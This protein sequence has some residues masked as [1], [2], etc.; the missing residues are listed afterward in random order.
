MRNAW[1]LVLATML[2]LHVVT[3]AG[4]MP[5]FEHGRLSLMLCPDGEWTAPATAMRDMGSGHSPARPHQPCPY[6]AAASIPFAASGVAVVTPV[7]EAISIAAVP[8]LPSFN[9][10]ARFD[11][12]HSTGPPIRA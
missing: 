6:A 4:Y 12:P 9:V 2:A 7:V 8:A 11:R 1:A 5:A 10:E 3:S